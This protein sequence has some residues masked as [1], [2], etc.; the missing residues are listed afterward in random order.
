MAVKKIRI[1]DIKSKIARRLLECEIGILKMMNHNN[2]IRCLDIHS[3]INNCYII[4]E[5][6][7]G[8]DLDHFIKKHHNFCQE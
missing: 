7:Q 1:G 5:L 6:C 3:S 2:V 4:T 8:G